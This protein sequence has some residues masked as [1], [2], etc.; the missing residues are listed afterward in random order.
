MLDESIL[1][2][3]SELPQNKIT[4]LVSRIILGLLEKL[5]DSKPKVADSAEL[6]LFCL[7]NSPCI[8]KTAIINA[9]CKRVR[10]KESKGGRTVKARLHF[11]EKMCAEFGDG[12]AWKKCVDFALT[13]KVFEHKEVGVRD[14]SKTL[15]VTLV[16][17]NGEVVLE[18]LQNDDVPERLLNEFRTTR[19]LL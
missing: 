10:S 18:P 12:V 4:P 15:I 17:A 19:F 7:A 8:D 5:A 16:A 2:L 11:L 3:E 13:N 14:A 9:A 1:Q 6:A